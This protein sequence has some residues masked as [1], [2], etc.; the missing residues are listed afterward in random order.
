MAVVAY[1]LAN[2]VATT[3]CTPRCRRRARR[4]RRQR[5]GSRRANV[6]VCSDRHRGVVILRKLIAGCSCTP[7]TPSSPTTHRVR[8]VL[9][10]A[11]RRP[12]GAEAEARRLP[13]RVR[14]HHGPSRL[15]GRGRSVAD[16]RPPLHRRH[17]HGAQGHLLPNVHCRAGNTTIAAGDTTEEIDKL[18]C[19][20][21]ATSGRRRLVAVA[22]G[23]RLDR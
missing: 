4:R 16:R 6:A 15:R 13:G 10:R 22:H 17:K 8:A 9:L 21:A 3:R 7:S 23:A 1:R 2:I 11:A 20:G 18:R 14:A 19:G 12:G 5:S